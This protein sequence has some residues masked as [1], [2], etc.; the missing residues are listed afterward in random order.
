MLMSPRLGSCR[1][2]IPRADHKGNLT[3]ARLSDSEREK[4]ANALAATLATGTP[5]PSDPAPLAT[6]TPATGFTIAQLV[7]AL[8]TL[9]A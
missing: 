3:M 8:R 2:A 4:R 5:A 1:T 7:A 6:G 9:T